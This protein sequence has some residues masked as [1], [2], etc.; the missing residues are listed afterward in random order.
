MA[1]QRSERVIRG[2]TSIDM[3]WNDILTEMAAVEE[4]CIMVL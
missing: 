4:D 1:H 3:A 2:R